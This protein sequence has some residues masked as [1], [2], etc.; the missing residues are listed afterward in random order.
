MPQRP[1]HPLRLALATATAVALTGGLLVCS[2][3]TASAAGSVRQYKADFN[4]DGYGDVAFAAPYA[5]VADKGMAGYVAVVY[6]SSTGLNPA[7][8][9]VVSQN[10]AGVPGTAESE[11]SFGEALAV[12]DLNGDGYTD[13]AVGDPGEDVGSDVDGGSVTV[14]WGSAAGIKN[15]TSVKDPAPTAHDNWGKLLTAGDFNGDGKADLAVGTGASHVYMI[16]GRFTTAGV[17]GTA[18]K[19]NLP[20]KAEYGADAMKAGD[21]NGDKKADLVLT[22]RIDDTSDASGSWSKGVAYMG[23]SSGLDTAMSRPLNGGTSIALGDIDG[24]GYDEIALGNVFTKED[25]HTGT[26]GGQVVVIRGSAGGPINGDAPMAELTQDSTGVPGTDEANDGFGGSVSI[27]DTNGDGYGDLAIGVVFEDIGSAEDTGA[28]VLMN[29]SSSGVSRTGGRTFSQATTGVP[30]TAE[31]MDYFGS[32]VLL[33]DVNKDGRADFTIAAGFEDEGVGA[34][35]AL[36]SSAD[37]VGTSNS[38]S[39]G[40]G[41]FGL[42]RTYGAFGTGLLG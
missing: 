33:S 24:D 15:G 42:S 23:A 2:A 13:L 28:T 10:T 39:F 36:R 14:L 29:G 31:S 16:R 34:V 30:G 17:T 8:R 22:Y 7:K 12:A 25:D 5:K 27:A 26:L 40:P 41:T 3:A 20:E 1:S 9:T 19:I 38:R 18:Q 37:G 11:D 32:D 35:T 21:T 4:G 6:G